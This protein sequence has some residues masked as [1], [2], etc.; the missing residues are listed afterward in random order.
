MPRSARCLHMFL[1]FVLAAPAWG[2]ALAAPAEY[3][4]ADM[5]YYLRSAVVKAEPRAVILTPGE[6]H[7]KGD[8]YFVKRAKPPKE[9]YVQVVRDWLEPIT[10]PSMPASLGVAPD[11]MQIRETQGDVQVEMPS[12]PGTFVPATEEM[13]IPNGTVV[14]TGAN[15]TAAVLFGGVNSVRL[16]P[17]SQASV[18]QT[19]AT[20]LRSTQVD[21]KSGAA[22]S[23]VGLRKGEKQDY[24][25]HTPFGVASARGT[26]F[27]TVAMPDRTDVW[28]AQGTVQ[29]D[30]PNG[31]MVGMVKSAGTG[32]L[33]IIRFPVM[34]DAHQAMMATAETM[35]AA[36]NF[37]PTV[38]LKIKALRDE[39]TQGVKL[40]S[41]EKKY[42]SLIKRVP[43]LIK[44]DLVEPPPPP[45]LAPPPAPTPSPTV[46]PPAPEPAAPPASGAEMPAPS[47]SPVMPPT[48]PPPVSA[49][50]TGAI[51]PSMGEDASPL[52][53]KADATMAP[54]VDGPAP[55]APLASTDTNAPA[56]A[57]MPM[58]ST[59]SATATP[60]GALVSTK[61]AKKK[62]K[63]HAA[64]ATTPNLDGVTPTPDT[65]HN[66]STP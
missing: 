63:H 2:S 20:D 64:A 17:N 60:P 22:F 52:G 14:K 48:T 27:V 41:Q 66:G 43:C 15:G 23:K 21:L 10:P 37:I 35:T 51:N 58:V 47:G 16:S 28:I 55:E 65:V 32:T 40:S 4:Q 9:I 38:N 5:N 29:F 11:V 36:M 61:P 62:K 6:Y 33:K 31:T 50:A 57:P 24:Q 44:L 3:K 25:V 46:T 39:M 12:G 26:D 8:S 53:I 59:N 30:Q 13:P 34:A 54:R 18:Q 56:A 7:Q 19:V 1:L 45:T 49:P 42:L